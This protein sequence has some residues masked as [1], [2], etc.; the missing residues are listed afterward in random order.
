MFQGHQQLRTLSTFEALKKEETPYPQCCVFPRHVTRR[1]ESTQNA[2][3][4]ALYRS[5]EL[6]D[7]VVD[8]TSTLDRFALTACRSA[9][10]EQSPLGPWSWPLCS[11]TGVHMLRQT[12]RQ[13]YA[14]HTCAIK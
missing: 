10:G 8:H 12:A 4:T 7:S 14:V 5:G 3:T 13:L 1:V 6:H 11:S 9:A 2:S